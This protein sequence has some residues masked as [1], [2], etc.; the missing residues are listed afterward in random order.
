VVFRGEPAQREFI[1]FCLRDNRV[2]AAMNANVWDVVEPLQAVIASE[3]AV[4]P[5]RLTDPDTP[6]DTDALAL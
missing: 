3:R 5:A 4:D 1:A 2:V 6:L